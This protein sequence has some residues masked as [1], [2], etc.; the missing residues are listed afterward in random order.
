MN[1]EKSKK[2]V[3]IGTKANKEFI[4]YIVL[5]TVAFIAAAVLVAIGF[6][7]NN[8]GLKIYS[9]VLSALF[10]A[11][12]AVSIR[13]L[14]AS[15]DMIYVCDTFL[16]VKRPLYTKKIDIKN[17]KAVKAAVN[18]KTEEFTVRIAYGEKSMHLKLKNLE[19]DDL[20][21]L[22]KVKSIR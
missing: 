9:S 10:A 17:I 18:E 2:N 1:A 5:F 19:K 22:K 20:I 21:K 13:L 12:I 6:K 15:Y 7:N 4:Y 3:I 16:Y 8:E 14:Y 11:A